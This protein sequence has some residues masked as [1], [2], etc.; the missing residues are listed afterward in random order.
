MNMH[1]PTTTPERQERLSAIVR[2]LGPGGIRNQAELAE[3]LAG[4]G[5]EVNQATLSRDL[6][7]LRVVKGPDGWTLPGG[8]VLDEL[9]SACRQWLEAAEAVQNQLVLRTAPGGATA[10]ALAL[11]HA[12]ERSVAG[13]IAGDDTV[14]VVCR[15]ARAASA[16]AKSLTARSAR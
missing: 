14:L 2:V 10:L 16:L 13:T 6:R 7:D 15:S 5:Y 8:A 4:L 11:D 1:P 9:T 3:T 12:E